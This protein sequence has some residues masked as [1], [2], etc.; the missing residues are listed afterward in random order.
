MNIFGIFNY[1]KKGCV[2]MGCKRKKA[3][4][5]KGS[6]NE[7]LCLTCHIKNPPICDII[8]KKE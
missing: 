6:V 4:G 2:I 7:G 8:P 1:N 5:L 3:K